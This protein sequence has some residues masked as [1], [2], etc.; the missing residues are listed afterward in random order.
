LVAHLRRS[1]A[2]QSEDRRYVTV[3]GASGEAPP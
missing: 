1:G 3:L 2:R